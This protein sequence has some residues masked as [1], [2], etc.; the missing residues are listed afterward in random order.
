MRNELLKLIGE[1]P[2][3]HQ[4]PEVVKEFAAKLEAYAKAPGVDS[5][6]VIFAIGSSVYGVDVSA[7]DSASDGTK[8]SGQSMIID[9]DYMKQFMKDVFLSYGCTEEQAETSSEV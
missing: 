4:N 3:G 2:G 9:F 5:S 6:D 7:T 1:N 8:P